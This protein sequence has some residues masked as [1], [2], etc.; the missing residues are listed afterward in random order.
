MD[1][2]R[3]GALACVGLI[4]A[5]GGACPAAAER[6]AAADFVYLGAFRLPEG[7]ARPQTFAYGGAAMAF[8]PDG[9]PG[10]AADGAP[11]SLFVV[12]HPRLAY[13]ELADGGQIAELTIPKPS[14]S[15]QVAALPRAR[16][17]QRFRDVARGRFKGLDEIPRVGL[18]YLETAA[19]G[20]LL[21]IAWGQHFQ[22]DPPVPSHAWVRPTL[23][24]PEFKGE[25]FVEAANPYAVQ[26][27][28]L[29][30]PKDWAEKHA[31]GR[32]LAAGRFRDGGWSG[33]GPSLYAYR[34]WDPKTGA[35]AAPGATLQS[36]ALLQY[37][38]SRETDAMDRA[39]AGYQHPDEWEGGAWI[40]T[41]SGKT[42]VLFAGTKGLGAK[43]W[44]GFVHPKGPDQVC[45]HGA[46]VGEFPACR[47]AAGGL[48][49]Q[50]DLRECAGHNDSRGWWSTRFAARFILYDPDDLA[51]VAAGRMKPWE[52]Q[53]YAH[54]DIDRHFFLN[55]GNVEPAMLGTG[56][57][58]RFRI[59]GVAY[60]RANDLLYVL[61]PFAD[62]SQPVVHVWQLR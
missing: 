19:T 24:R 7:G 29:E 22:P 31:G 13:G 52:P 38:T 5:I 6:L 32:V 16:F 9:D 20:P 43:Y 1:A 51:K 18:L 23:D 44:Y 56:P 48:C 47:T 4:A 37:P 10:G 27:Y 14:P 50:A 41:K 34:P 28:L 57:Q 30:I 58:R 39:L 11:G 17:L 21:H 2:V 42:A 60:D 26:G 25:W 3:L 36:I 59:G 61:E 55:P 53:P 35:A 40:T 8:R 54:L 15:R 49:P 46:S 33:L 62:A 45:V 12:G